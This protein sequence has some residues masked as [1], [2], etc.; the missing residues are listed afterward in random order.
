MAWFFILLTLAVTIVLLD[1]PNLSWPIFVAAILVAV[2]GSYSSLQGLLIWPVGLVLLYHRRR[3]LSVFIAWVVAMGVTVALYFYNFT[4]SAV[5]NFHLFLEYPSWFLKFFVFALGDVVGVPEGFPAPPNAAVMTFGVVLLVLAV[6][7]LLKWGIARDELSGAPIGVALIVFGL[8]FDVLI[9]QGRF[10]RGYFFASQ[11]RYSTY[12]ILV[13]AG[14][15][16]AA[17]DGARSLARAK[18]D[19]VRAGTGWRSRPVIASIRSA[20]LWVKDQLDRIN[21]SVV[22][23]IALVALVIQV[24]FSFHYAVVGA[25]RSYLNQVTAGS[26]TRNFDRESGPALVNHLYFTQ[27]PGWLRTEV[28]FLREHHLS[29]FANGVNRARSGSPRSAIELNV[30]A[31]SGSPRRQPITRHRP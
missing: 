30:A 9:T 3:R 17:L 31:V 12:D 1:R 8:L 27:S 4:T 21:P 23:R 22:L 16:L 15:Y 10:W 5:F 29:L 11:S 14:I 7:A 6:L 20:S 24:G 19:V 25:R 26:V 2:V 18:S 28:Q 13:L